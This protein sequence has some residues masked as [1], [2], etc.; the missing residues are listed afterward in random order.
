MLQFF[1][2]KDIFECV[3]ISQFIFGRYCRLWPPFTN[4][5]LRKDLGWRWPTPYTRVH[6]INKQV[7]MDIEQPEV[8]KSQLPN[9]MGQR[10]MHADKNTFDRVDLN[11]WYG[12]HLP[13]TAEYRLPTQT[14]RSPNPGSLRT[15]STVK[16]RVCRLLNVLFQFFCWFIFPKNCN[17]R[18]QISNR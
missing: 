13:I 5:L 12:T 8:P 15:S 2:F 4:Q 16:Y 10:Y 6:E 9:D 14:P 3:S 1:V 18:S 11:K 17:I 7:N